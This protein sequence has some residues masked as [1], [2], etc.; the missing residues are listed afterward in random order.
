MASP[1]YIRVAFLWAVFGL[2]A[3]AN[4][5]AQR[6]TFRQYGVADGL[7]NLS[8]N[9]L[10]QDRAGYLWVGTDNGLFRYDGDSFQEFG[11]EEG[12]PNAEILHLAESPDG[13]LWVATESG[14]ARRTG[15]RFKQV[16]DHFGHDTGDVVLAETAIRLRDAV[17]ESDCAAR[18]DGDEF[19]LLLVS[20]QD[21]AGIEAVCIRLVE[22]VAIGVSF[23]GENLKV[24]CG[25]GIAV[26]PDDGDTEEGLYKSADQAL[27]DAKRTGQSTFCWHQQ[28]SLVVNIDGQEVLDGKRSGRSR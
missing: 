16:N 11:H 3:S 14:V 6:N 5:L 25:V 9:C 1:T 7:T 22:S 18:L 27:Y 2:L 19:G 4:L 17:R 12:L 26:F 13:V 10:L 24:G 8:V 28:H 23:K 21:R 20:V 15:D